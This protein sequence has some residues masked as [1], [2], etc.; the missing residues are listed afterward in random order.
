MSKRW[1]FAPLLATAVAAP[2]ML[3]D[4]KSATDAQNE[5]GNFAAG[6]FAPSDFAAND[7]SATLTGAGGPGFVQNDPRLNGLTAEE[8]EM[9][10]PNSI[11][12]APGAT[13]FREV[14]RF[15]G[16]AAWLQKNWPVVT[17]S[18]SLDGLTSYRVPLVTGPNP[19]DLTGA[20]TYYFN[21]KNFCERISFYGFTGDATRVIQLGTET[22]G[23][24]AD[25]NLG[26]GIYTCQFGRKV[27]SVMVIE[28]AAIIVKDESQRRIPVMIELNNPYGKYLLSPE[29][30]EMIH[31]LNGL[32]NADAPRSRIR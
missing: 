23:L 11:S 22:F 20:L 15:D 3:M 17:C 2:A 29:T 18:R 1:L 5:N 27:R 10:N 30:Q 32:N 8:A 25:R 13:D 6:D 14:F 12:Y 7:F 16:N 24:N 26:S 31:N 21:N 28:Y 4:K 19:H 9:L